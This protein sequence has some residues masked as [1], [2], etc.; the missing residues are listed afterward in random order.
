MNLTELQRRLTSHLV[1]E[2]DTSFHT[3]EDRLAALNQAYTK[4]SDRFQLEL[5]PMPSGGVKPPDY[6]SPSNLPGLYNAR[7]TPLSLGTDEPW[8]GRYAHIHHVISLYAAF[9]LYRDKGP[10][11]Y[12]RAMFWKEQ[13]EE[14][15]KEVALTLLR[16]ESAAYESVQDGTF[17]WLQAQVKFNLDTA[18]ILPEDGVRMFPPA[19]RRAAIIHAYQQITLEQE[20][21]HREAVVTFPPDYE[22][23]QGFTTFLPGDFIAPLARPAMASGN[24][25][26]GGE[27]PYQRG[28]Q[29]TFNID[30]GQT[31]KTITIG[32]FRGT[33][34]T[35]AIPYIAEPPPLVNQTDRPWAGEHQ[36]LIRLIPLLASKDM[37]R[38]RKET[39]QLSRFWQ[40][41]YERELRESKKYLR[42]FKLGQAN[43]LMVGYQGMLGAEGIDDSVIHGA[44]RIAPSLENS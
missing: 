27:P 26:I 10:E 30:Y 16:E 28:S 36:P 29:G 43:R 5:V 17:G 1:K 23:A 3:P 14:A 37:M 38:G 41:E 44:D 24:P 8:A 15:T 25:V 12:E 13:Y 18:D 35:I 11:M 40:N 42:M 2:E 21:I 33:T 7:P 31:P 19:L 4:T 9:I 20:L 39:Y 32:G 22:P 34:E 6:M